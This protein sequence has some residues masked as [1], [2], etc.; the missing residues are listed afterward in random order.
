MLVLF[1]PK[2]ITGGSMF[3]VAFSM[4]C[5]E[6]NVGKRMLQFQ[7]VRNSSLTHDKVTLDWNVNIGLIKE[8]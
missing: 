5:V 3:D 1:L 7:K 4:F 6:D 2:L 8:E